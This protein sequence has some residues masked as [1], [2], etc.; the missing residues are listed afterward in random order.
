VQFLDP[1]ALNET[2]T[3]GFMGNVCEVLSE[4]TGDLEFV[5]ALAE[6]W[7]NPEASKWIIKLRKGVKSQ[8]G[9]DFNADDVI[10]SWKRCLSEGSDMKGRAGLIK[11]MKKIDDYTVEAITP[12]PNPILMQ[13]MAWLLY[14]GQRMVRRA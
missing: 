10:F 5:P 12:S 14:H 7:S 2:F 13:E 9:G 6:S 4:Y 8:E 11:E 3:M 1:H